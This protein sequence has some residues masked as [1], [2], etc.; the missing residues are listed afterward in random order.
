MKSFFDNRDQHVGG[1]S[2]PNLRLH[3]VLARAQERFDSQVLLDPFEKQLHLPTAFVQRRNGRRGQRQIVG[4]KRD[5]LAVLVF[6]SHTAHRLRIR[7]AGL[8][9]WQSTDLI[10]HHV[11]SDFVHG[12]RVA[13]L[14][15]G[16]ALGAGYKERARCVHR[17]QAGEVQIPPV[18]QVKRA[19]LDGQRIQHTD[20]VHLA[21]ADMNEA[22]NIAA[23]VQERMQF[24]R[25]FG[26]AKRCPRVQRQAQIDGRGIERVD[27]LLQIHAK[28]VAGV[29]RASHADQ[30]L[31]HIGVDLPGAS[32]V[33]IGQRVARY[34]GAAKPHVIQP[35]G[36]GTQVDLNIAQAL[37]VGEL[38]K[39]H[40]QE[41]IQTRKIFDFVIARVARHAARECSL[42]QVRHE[43]RKYEFAL[44]HECASRVKTAK[45]DS[46]GLRCSNRNQTIASIY[47]NISLTYVSLM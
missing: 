8:N 15:L 37:A 14:E 6:D 35:R 27:H 43:L 39:V 18:H 45:H 36:L 22:G 2:N 3:R 33:G 1:Q 13:P 7:F 17:I 40:G 11:R 21:I 5:P 28:R 25:R 24:D 12:L 23:Q 19:R 20:F 38:G 42:G 41:L 47:A 16:I 34:G 29:Q 10:E 32:G 30:G 26:C 31:T 4:Q 46:S 44:M 9:Q